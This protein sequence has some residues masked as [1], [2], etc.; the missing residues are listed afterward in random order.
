[1]GIG[2][3]WKPPPAPWA[4]P[5]MAAAALGIAPIPDIAEL[6]IRAGIEPCQVGGTDIAPTNRALPK[7]API[8]PPIPP[9]PPNG[10]RSGTALPTNL[11]ASPANPAAFAPANAAEPAELLPAICAML[12]NGEIAMLAGYIAIC[13]TDVNGESPDAALSN[14]DND[15]PD[16]A[17]VTPVPKDATDDPNDDSSAVTCDPN[18]DIQP[19]NPVKLTGGVSNCVNV[20]ATAVDVV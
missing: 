13:A 20:E 8:P 14:V 16:N 2:M 17:E 4:A 11:V 1:M 12:I 19:V 3:G 18:D 9:A 10:L 5:A 15:T 7:S 6:T